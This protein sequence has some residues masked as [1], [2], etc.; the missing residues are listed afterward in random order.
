MYWTTLSLFLAAESILHPILSW[1]PFYSWIRLGAHLYL[2]LPGQQGSVFLYQTYVHPF[3]YEHEREIDQFISSSHDNAKKAGLQYLKQAIEWAKVNVLGLPPRRPTPPS[4]RQVSYSTSLLQR[5]VMPTA[6]DS[7]AQAGAGDL[8]SVLGNVMQQAGYAKSREL[9]PEDLAASGLIPPSI[10][11][12]ERVNYIFEQRDRLRTL[13][14]AFDQEASQSG[15]HEASSS[16]S[17]PL[18]AGGFNKPS[19]LLSKSR[20]E[21]DFEDL[22]NED[23]PPKRVVP[24]RQPSWT[25]NASKWIWGTYGEKDSAEIQKKEE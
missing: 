18:S 19:G 11:G 24:D 4:S 5:F 16:G 17:P 13:L 12:Q 14:Q 6:R 22:G 25:N 3:L 7:T 1:V 23:L 2:V 10:S 21:L 15:H 8:F 20:S 9:Q